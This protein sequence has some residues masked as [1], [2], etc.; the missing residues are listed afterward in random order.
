M[1]KQSP[2]LTRESDT[3]PILVVE[4]PKCGWHVQM[5]RLT[6][7]EILELS[8]EEGGPTDC[9]FVTVSRDDIC[10]CYLTDRNGEPTHGPEKVYYD[11]TVEFGPHTWTTIARY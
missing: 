2:N 8:I 5:K 6:R 3:T 1:I 11:E 9:R 10:Q 4:C 7:E